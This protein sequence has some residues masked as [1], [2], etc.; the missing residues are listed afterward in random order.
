[1]V[2]RD[3]EE[4]GRVLEATDDAEDS[5]CTSSD[6][7]VE[8]RVERE[9][10]EESGGLEGFEKR[11]SKGPRFEENEV[12]LPCSYSVEFTLIDDLAA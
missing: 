7:S 3:L 12:K 10:E 8:V 6:A 9:R 2:W 4:V 1:M 11:E 5:A